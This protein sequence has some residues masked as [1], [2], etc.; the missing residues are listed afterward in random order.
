VVY[1]YS[2]PMRQLI[3]H[4]SVLQKFFGTGAHCHVHDCDERREPD[5]QDTLQMLNA[6]EF[7]NI[8]PANLV[9]NALEA[10][11]AEI[12]REVQV[13]WDKW[14]AHT[15]K[16]CWPEHLMLGPWEFIMLY[17]GYSMHSHPK[18]RRPLW[19]RSNDATVFPVECGDYVRHISFF[20]GHEEVK[21]RQK[22]AA[23]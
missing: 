11:R 20:L 1:P 22:T 12:E 4:L 7:F 21:R 2:E 23:K 10:E 14:Y 5:A 13:Y 16:D 9:R 18:D 3:D 15:A 6:L 17:P 8:G 19:S